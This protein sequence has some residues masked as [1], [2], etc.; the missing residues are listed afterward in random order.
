MLL[1]RLDVF[2]LPD[3]ADPSAAL[4]LCVAEN[5]FMGFPKS[6][7]GRALFKGLPTAASAGVSARGFGAVGVASFAVVDV[8]VTRC[9][10]AVT[11]GP[12]VC[13]DSGVALP[14]GS[15]ECARLS[16]IKC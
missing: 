15:A 3:M 6:T 8:P 7:L 4:R 14:S 12:V 9:G 1:P 2:V 10:V 11:S 13:V 16:C 5:L